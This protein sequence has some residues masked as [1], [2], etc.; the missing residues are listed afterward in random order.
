MNI[1]SYQKLLIYITQLIGKRL[2][3]V[4]FNGRIMS[5]T[6]VMITRFQ[7]LIQKRLEQE[8][9]SSEENNAAYA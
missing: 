3:Q 2:N 7:V 9:K 8:G 6:L 4:G 5:G 1:I